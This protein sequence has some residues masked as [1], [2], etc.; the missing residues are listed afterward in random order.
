MYAIVGATGNT[1]RVVAERLLERGERVRALVRDP[2]KAEDLRARGAEVVAVDLADR[3]TTR[4]AFAGVTR[5]YLMLPPSPT[6]PDPLA[7]GRAIAETLVD[8][9]TENRLEHV[10][11]LS[12]VGAHRDA[13]TGPILGLHDFEDR[14]EHAGVSFT[15]VRAAYFA[16]NWAGMIPAVKGDGVLPNM[17]GDRDHAIPMVT[18]LDIGRTAA[19][20]LVE[21]PSAKGIIELEGAER[22]SPTDVAAHL[23]KRLGRSVQIVDVPFAAQPA[24]LQQFG[25]SARMGELYRELNEGVADGTVDFEGPPARHVRGERSARAVFDALIG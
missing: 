15:A 1:G 5:A 23:G 24:Q 12:S 8:A 7:H 2:N 4:A 6:A 20:A 10:V 13:R 19:D 14:L 22:L 16:E 21:G 9:V 18:T 17:L 11:L 3:E 25:F